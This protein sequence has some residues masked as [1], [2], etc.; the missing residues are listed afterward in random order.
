MPTTRRVDVTALAEFRLKTKLLN[1]RPMLAG[2]D[3]RLTRI[4]VTRPALA[5]ALTRSCTV[6]AEIEHVPFD[7]VADDRLSITMPS[8]EPVPM[9][10]RPPT[11]QNEM[12]RSAWPLARMPNVLTVPLPISPWKPAPMNV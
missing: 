7:C 10:V 5:L 11:S 8:T 12:L 1:T 2:F 4:P 9:P 6:L 3:V